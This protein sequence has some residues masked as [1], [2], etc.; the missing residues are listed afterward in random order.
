MLVHVHMYVCGFPETHSIL[1]SEIGSL[2]EPD[3]LASELRDPPVFYP[4]QQ[5]AYRH[6][7]IQLQ[8]LM[9]L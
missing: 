2:I 3:W 4:P 1:L 5:W 9:L 6:E 7:V 8:S